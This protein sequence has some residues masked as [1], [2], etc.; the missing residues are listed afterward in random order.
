VVIVPLVPD[1][2]RE[3]SKTGDCICHDCVGVGSRGR[4]AVRIASSGANVASKSARWL[5]A[6]GIR[7]KEEWRLTLR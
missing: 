1:C 6:V 3:V 5:V 2:G 7:H 4:G